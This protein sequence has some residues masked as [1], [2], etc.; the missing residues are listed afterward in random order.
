MSFYELLVCEYCFIC[1]TNNFKFFYSHRFWSGAN[2]D[3]KTGELSSIP[4]KKVDEYAD[5]NVTHFSLKYPIGWNVYYSSPSRE[6]ESYTI[7]HPVNGSIE[8]SITPFD[9]SAAQ[10]SGLSEKSI[11]ENNYS[12]LPQIFP[13]VSTLFNPVLRMEYHLN[14]K[15]FHMI[16]MQWMDTEWDLLNST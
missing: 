10:T 3:T 7:E 1:D 4:Q 5:L 13:W 11:Q 2:S 14:L 15:K 6:F 12:D 9:V 16:N 8:I